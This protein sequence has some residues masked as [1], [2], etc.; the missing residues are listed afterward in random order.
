MP[1][2]NVSQ[3]LPYPEGDSA[4]P[5][6]KPSSEI[7]DAEHDEDLVPQNSL[8]GKK[9]NKSSVLNGPPTEYFRGKIQSLGVEYYLPVVLIANPDANFL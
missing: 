1:H 3:G 4:A 2:R 7:E 9:W 8:E 5:A 6:W